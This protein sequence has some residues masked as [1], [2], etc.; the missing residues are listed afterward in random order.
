MAADRLDR[1]RRLLQLVVPQPEPER[2]S[3]WMKDQRHLHDE[4]T[5]DV[6]SW[7]QQKMVGQNSTVE[8][9]EVLRFWRSLVAGRRVV[10]CRL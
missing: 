1:A 4:D 7:S 2:R 3:L 6:D 5:A 10:E 8:L 9:Q